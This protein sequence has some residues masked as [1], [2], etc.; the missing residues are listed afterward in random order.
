MT[1]SSL[2]MEASTASTPPAK[3]SP[4]SLETVAAALLRTFAHKN[5]PNVLIQVKSKGKT[6]I[7]FYEIFYFIL[8]RGKG[9]DKKNTSATLILNGGDSILCPPIN[10]LPQVLTNN[11]LAAVTPNVGPPMVAMGAGAKD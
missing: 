8:A 9:R 6:V 4:S 2:V 7:F 5:L 1:V 3:P 11:V 10:R